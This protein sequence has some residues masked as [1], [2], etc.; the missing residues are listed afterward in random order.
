MPP[1]HLDEAVE[2]GCV[3]FEGER[4]ADVVIH[5]THQVSLELMVRAQEAEDDPL[6]QAELDLLGHV[7]VQEER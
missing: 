1:R 2:V 7:L 4:S 6:D 5:K 3:F